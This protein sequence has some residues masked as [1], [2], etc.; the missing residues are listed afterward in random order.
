MSCEV[1]VNS[2]L[3]KSIL[4][5][6]SDIGSALKTYLNYKK[7]GYSDDVELL[8]LSPKLEEDVKFDKLY[9]A[10][11]IRLLNAEDKLSKLN[12]EINQV[13]KKQ[14]NTK[15]LRKR[16]IEL[17][18]RIAKLELDLAVLQTNKVVEGLESIYQNDK[19]I[20][21]NLIE[22]GN[23]EDLYEA[24][25]I[26][27][28][29]NQMGD[30][31]D[32]TT[33]SH[34][35][36]SKD[37]LED[38]DLEGQDVKTLQQ[39]SNTMD[40]KK[41][42]WIQSFKN[43]IEEVSNNSNRYKNKN[44]VSY[45][46][47][48]TAMKDM[49]II[50]SNVVSL[51]EDGLFGNSSEISKLMMDT[52][53]EDRN[54]ATLE[55]TKKTK[56]HRVL[57]EKA[58][59][60][61][62]ELG[63]D[64]LY[65]IFKQLKNGKFTGRLASRF[66]QNYFD[67]RRLFN[68]SFYNKLGNARETKDKN[69]IAKVYK[70]QEKWKRDNE[71][72][73]DINKLPEFTSEVDNEYKN[74]LIEIL[75]E[76]GYEEQV[77]IQ[78]NMISLYKDNEA[79]IKDE[80]NEEDFEIWQR[81][82]SPYWGAKYWYSKNKEEL[83]YK[84]KYLSE[85]E[86]NGEKASYKGIHSLAVIPKKSNQGQ[87]LGYYDSNFEKIE[88]NKDIYNYYNYMVDT[89]KDIRSNLPLEF[90]KKFD[91]IYDI[92]MY[93]KDFME[94][95]L[96]NKGFDI[97][98]FGKL[99]KDSF[100]DHVINSLSDEQLNTE[101]KSS[102]PFA[103]VKDKQNYGF[104]GDRK[105]KVISLFNLKVLEYSNE[106]S[107]LKENIPVEILSKLKLE[108]QEEIA[109]SSSFDLGKIMEIYMY[110]AIHT[111]HRQE[112]LPM[113]DLL[114]DAA[115][116]IPKIK[117]NKAGQTV[118]EEGEIS[119]DKNDI[120][121]EELDLIKN[122]LKIHKG[123]ST[124]KVE[125]KSEKIIYNKDEKIEKLRI[126][127]LLESDSLS[128]QDREK[129]EVQLNKLGKEI[130]GSGLVDSILGYLRF[131]GL[132]WNI[133]AMLPNA[134]AGYFANFIEAS[135]G[136][137][138]SFKAMKKAYRQIT[139]S[140]LKLASLGKIQTSTSKKIANFMSR[141]DVL[142]DSTNEFQKAQV[143]SKLTGKL[144]NLHPMILN[145]IVEYPNQATTAISRLMSIELEENL[146]VWDILNEDL[147]LKEEYKDKYSKWSF[148]GEL[149]QNEIRRIKELIKKVHGDHSEE[150]RMKFKNVLIGRMATFFKTWI[151]RTIVNRFGAESNTT[152]L[153]VQK[154]RY[155][156]YTEGSASFAGAIVGTT[157][158]P[159]IGTVVGGFGGWIAGKLYG[160]KS[161]EKFLNDFFGTGKQ[162][163]RKLIR[164]KSNEEDFN[165]VDAA[166]MRANVQE[167]IFMLG[168]IGTYL[169]AK[170][171]LYNPDEPDKEQVAHNLIIN[172]INRLTSDLSFFTNPQTPKG[173]VDQA[174]PIAR[175]LNNG[176]KIM[177]SSLKVIFNKELKA[178]ENTF[179][180]NLS[181]N[182]P[183]AFR[184]I[185]G[186][187]IISKAD[188]EKEMFPNQGWNYLLYGTE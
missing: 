41:S 177:G 104:V 56:E 88:A 187:P 11:E 136:R 24:Q 129:L 152:D 29:Y 96:G 58:Q 81:V 155:K 6:D 131:L 21:D 98:S 62:K 172:Q 188:M 102:D 150:G 55:L 181:K 32:L 121:K 183:G 80:L 175:V 135:D 179:K 114:E 76:K 3:Y 165:D 115:R 99:S 67:S 26:I 154:G 184:P 164:A 18:D 12:Y 166:N 33:N 94:K 169:I 101:F 39:W 111:K 167:L 14:G 147:T 170:L 134:A 23:I 27:E 160:R 171:A 17:M 158:M 45:E 60:A 69:R 128:I 130:T 133:T 70:E 57:L 95:L 74:E 7:N 182:I 163:I 66:S 149:M 141:A 97:L 8:S 159:G 123:I 146:S 16:K 161:E 180:E 106:N 54:K 51:G 173:L 73:F 82:N 86:L 162:L 132:G 48:T 107:I 105:S 34:P 109:N 119:I 138:I 127:K 185:F 157:F 50:D 89:L 19:E 49:S 126:E 31:T 178:N 36:Y 78:K 151:A 145:K 25:A 20:V 103:N 38:L 75:G 10:K 125:G 52:I 100:Y 140:S 87:D 13:N 40:L 120:R 43:K 2:K 186:E 116:K 118:Y 91:T 59:E 142:L 92:P 168:M 30:F 68:K 79:F 110:Q 174:F 139:H 44:K 35:L 72:I 124:T 85:Y 117:T 65:D 83:K 156:S 90:Q 1:E 144:A 108:S 37:L 9:N 137:L 64:N 5:Q 22:S 28:T 47:L 4:K 143:N 176:Y 61:L 71:I 46:E 84:D 77:E 42:K 63:T 153:G 53:L 15:N 113:L 93:Q 148:D 112:S 122:A